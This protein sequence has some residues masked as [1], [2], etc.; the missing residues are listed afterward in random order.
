MAKEVER[1]F[2][3]K[4]DGWRGL[5]EGVHYRQGYLNS[6]KE[7]T[8]RI[9]TVGDRA[10][11]TVKGLT[12][13]VTR[14]EFEYEIPYDDCVAMLDNL[15][16]KPIIEKTRYKIPMGGFV[17][18]IDEFAGVNEGLVV[19]E[20]ELPSPETPFEKP[21]WI[22]EEVSSDPRYFNNNLVAHPYTTWTK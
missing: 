10:V 17:W 16:E 5:A 14:M 11:I 18:E 21:D 4:G 20:I 1:K 9:R 3:V 6:V 19:A 12:V 8:V 13:G 22:G 7:R 15:A 2:L